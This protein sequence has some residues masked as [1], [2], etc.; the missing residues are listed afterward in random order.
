M[1]DP[2]VDR[3]ARLMEQP[4][5]FQLTADGRVR[6]SWKGRVVTT[7]AGQPA[8]KLAEE[9]AHASEAATQLALAK[10]TG[11]FKRGNERR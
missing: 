9:V 10:A 6:I 3:R 11:N 1:A 7:L 5:T 2:N 4:F 8:R